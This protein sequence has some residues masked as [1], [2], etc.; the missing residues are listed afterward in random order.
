MGQELVNVLSEI[1]RDG[2]ATEEG[3]RRLHQWLGERPDGQ[4]PA[5]DFLSR[6]VGERASKPEFT[7]RDLFELQFAVERVLPHPLRDQV[8]ARRQSAWSQARAT[9]NQVESLHNPGGTPAAGTAKEQAPVPAE[10]RP[11][12]KQLETICDLTMS[13][14][15]A[16]E[17]LPAPAETEE[18]FCQCPCGGCGVNIEFPVHGIGQTVSCPKCGSDIV[19]FDGSQGGQAVAQD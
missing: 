1:V 7:T 8:A 11:T 4:L 10:P 3:F 19:L 12:V 16:M 9:A 2:L 6:V 18:G 13:I 14:Q 17:T 15:P 5:M